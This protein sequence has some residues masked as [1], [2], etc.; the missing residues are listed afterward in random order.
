MQTWASTP[1][2]IIAQYHT[3]F[4]RVATKRINTRGRESIFDR[5]R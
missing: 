4:T 2:A 3:A 5:E 1:I